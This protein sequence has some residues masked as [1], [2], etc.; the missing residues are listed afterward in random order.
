[1]AVRH[2]ERRSLRAKLKSVEPSGGSARP[3]W[4]PERR[5]I[6]LVAAF[7][8]FI[9]VLS[10]ANRVLDPRGPGLQLLP[11]SA[12]VLLT[13]FESSLWALLTPGIF[14]LAARF[15][16]DRLSRAWHVPF[17]LGLGL[18]LGAG[19]NA[20]IDF[21]RFEILDTPARPGAEQ[22]V[23]YGLRRLWFLNDFIIYLGI[24]AAGFAR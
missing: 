12:P 4:R 24:L 10:M 6:V 18:I 9:A 15:N 20:A 7:W 11:P 23:F 2:H 3:A 19:V 5:E 21:V 16:P 1:M 17:L 8:A 13:L 22:S 14:W